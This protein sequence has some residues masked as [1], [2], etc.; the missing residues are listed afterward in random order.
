MTAETIALLGM[1]YAPAAG[2]LRARLLKDGFTEPQLLKSG[3]L[4]QRDEG[5]ARDRFRNRLMI[6]ICIILPLSH[7]PGGLF[8]PSRRSAQ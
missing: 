5:P 7:P 3:L 2:G 4:A 1:G 6:P 8:P